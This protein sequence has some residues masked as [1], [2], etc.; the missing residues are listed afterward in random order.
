[1]GARLTMDLNPTLR[2]APQLADA[3]LALEFQLSEGAS[4][5]DLTVMALR[6]RA[7]VLAADLKAACEA[8]QKFQRWSDWSQRNSGPDYKPGSA[9]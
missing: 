1:M 5:R 3:F 8:P 7:R 9:T 2:L 4:P 6:R